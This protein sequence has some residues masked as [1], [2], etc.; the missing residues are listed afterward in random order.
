MRLL[1]ALLPPGQTGCRHLGDGDAVQVRLRVDDLGFALGRVLEGPVDGLVAALLLERRHEGRAEHVRK[2]E[3]VDERLGH[4][5]HVGLLG[6]LGPRRLEG[7]GVG[8]RQGVDVAVLDAH[9]IGLGQRPK[10]RVGAGVVLAKMGQ[11]EGLVL[12]RVGELVGEH[13]ADI[14][15]QVGAAD[16]HPLGLRAVE[17]ED[18]LA[19]D[20]V[21]RGLEVG[22]AFRQTDGAQGGDG[23]GQLGLLPDAG[24]AAGRHL[25]VEGG[26]VEEVQGHGVLEAQTAAALDELHDVED[27]RVPG[28]GRRARRW[29]RARRR[30]RFA[31][32]YDR[33]GDA[34]AEEDGDA[35]GG[36]DL[37]APGGHPSTMA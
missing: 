26:V 17:A 18:R 7:L 28:G 4:V 36:H 19:G 15:R 1:D 14:G 30:R 10:G 9:G 33:R 25:L 5:G 31:G 22:S 34:R 13:H 12:E 16:E 11:S 21:L 24:R 23:V 29:L 6:L 27:P 3:I 35:G 32:P 8:G 37:A 2:G 20:L